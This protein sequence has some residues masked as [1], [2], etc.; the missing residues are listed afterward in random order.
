[1]EKNNEHS[2]ERNWEDVRLRILQQELNLF[3][4]EK[5]ELLDLCRK[6]D[7]IKKLNVGISI[8]R[9]YLHSE[10]WDKMQLI[11]FGCL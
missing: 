5:I 9:I 6:S 11:D 8:G 4:N 2:I 7:T 1:M 10:N 3:P